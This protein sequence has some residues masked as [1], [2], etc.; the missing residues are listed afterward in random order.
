MDQIL[1]HFVGSIVEVGLFP[2]VPRL[3]APPR[4]LFCSP[5]A[6]ARFEFVTRR[7]LRACFARLGLRLG[8]SPSCSHPWSCIMTSPGF[9]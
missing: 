1:A 3:R 2:G 9:Q 4:A 8:L 6:Q 7:D 5:A